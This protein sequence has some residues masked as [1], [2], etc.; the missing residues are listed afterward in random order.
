MAEDE[1]V[2]TIMID[3]DDFKVVNDTYG[4]LV[5][6][7]ILRLSVK[8]IRS[9]VRDEDLLGRYGGEEFII[10]VKET[11][12]DEVMAL[13]TRILEAFQDDAIH[14]EY[15]GKV[16]IIDITVSIGIA[17]SHVTGEALFALTDA[18]DG[19]ALYKAKGSGKNQIAVVGD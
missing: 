13:A 18:A 14:V 16:V 19:G 12:E 17:Y 15:N 11:S 10:F 3:I 6:D 8:R 4:H 7:E 9:L 2:G 1:V 5:G